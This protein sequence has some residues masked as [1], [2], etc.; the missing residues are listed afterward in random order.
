MQTQKPIHNN[1][2]PIFEEYLKYSEEV[3]GIKKSTLGNRSWHLHRF[4]NW[5]AQ[6]RIMDIN[7]I[8]PK[9]SIDYIKAMSKKYKRSTLGLKSTVIRSFYLFL[10]VKGVGHPKLADSVPVMK[11]IRLRNIPTY[12]NE[13]QEEKFLTSF[14]RNSRAGKRD[15]A[16]AMLLLRLG[17]RSCEVNGLKLE[18][19]DWKEGKVKIRNSKCRREDVLPLLAEVGEALADYIQNARS[20]TEHRQVFLRVTG[21]TSVP[22]TSKSVGSSMTSRLAQFGINL[23]AKGAHLM[24]RTVATR[25]IQRGASIKDIADVLRQRNLDTAMIYTKV[26]LPLLEQVRMSWP[27]NAN[28]L[29]GVR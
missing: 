23:P 25:M 17:L 18:D 5:L 19:I 3:A 10:R 11:T 16:M 9:D 8:T 26:N 2:K 24:R 6:R 13:K 21:D 29:G 20:K 27:S 1:F 4:F 15:Y 28:C 22:I 7:K 12:L 14:D